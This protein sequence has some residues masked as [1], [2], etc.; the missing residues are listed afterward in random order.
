[1]EKGARVAWELVRCPAGKWLC[2]L[3][4]R[5]RCEVVCVHV[6]TQVHTHEFM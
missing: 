1:M 4:V 2:A 6:C 3:S 5:E